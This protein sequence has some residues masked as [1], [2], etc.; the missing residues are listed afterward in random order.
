MSTVEKQYFHTLAI[1]WQSK[2]LSIEPC[3]R[4]IFND[5]FFCY[6]QGHPR[7]FRG[8]RVAHLSSFLC[9]DF[10]FLSLSSVPYLPNVACVSG[11]FIIAFPSVFSNVYSPNTR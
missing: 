1:F 9:C 2:H 10:K 11:L 6:L 3:Q 7:F 5:V 8:V 4:H